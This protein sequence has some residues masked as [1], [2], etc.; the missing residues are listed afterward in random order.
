[1][2][3]KYQQFETEKL[4]I[5]KFIGHFSIEHY[6]K[7][8]RLILRNLPIKLIDKVL[9]D[10]RDLKFNEM[11]ENLTEELDRIVEVRKNINN[12]KELARNEA[13]LVIWVDSP[14]P[15]AIVHLFINNFPSMDY[16]YCSTESN[17]IKLLDVSENFHHLEKTICNLE[18]TY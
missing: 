9:I 15:T 1:M 6:I 13:K 16:N 3:I 4:F 18:N 17:A 10:F 8:A 11:P 14:T 7:Y 5:Q 2:N 12:N